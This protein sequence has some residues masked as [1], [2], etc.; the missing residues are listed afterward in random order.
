MVTWHCL[1][2]GRRSW[3]MVAAPCF[4]HVGMM[5]HAAEVHPGGPEESRWDEKLA[6]VRGGAGQGRELPG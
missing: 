1:G 2:G 4:G 3:A 5:G 6:R